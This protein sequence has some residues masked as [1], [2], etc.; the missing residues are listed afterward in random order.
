MNE[1][2]IA[3]AGVAL[4]LGLVVA[5]P[6][7]AAEYTAVMT[8]DIKWMDAPSIGPGVKTAVIDGDP[9]AAGPFVIR[10]KVPPKTRIGVHIHPADENVTI[11]SGT[12]HFAPGDKFDA[13][14]AKAFSAGSYFSIAKGKPM[15]AFT[16][17]K[18]TVAQIHGIG[19]WGIT[20]LEPTGTAKKQP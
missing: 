13:K 14:T 15:Y 16:T 1:V 5:A 8:P 11:L 12:L 20:Y 19:P 4:S 7:S 9:K 3:A 2:R 17:D 10:L 6:A 18:E